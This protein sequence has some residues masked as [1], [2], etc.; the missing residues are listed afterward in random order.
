[1]DVT[2]PL[3][4]VH[5][6]LGIELVPYEA[7]CCHGDMWPQLTCTQWPCVSMGR[8]PK[9]LNCLALHGFD[10]LTLSQQHSPNMLHRNKA[11]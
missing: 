9:L 11:Y 4:L 7:C 5:G 2:D 8:E 6:Q 3:G 10:S 1:M